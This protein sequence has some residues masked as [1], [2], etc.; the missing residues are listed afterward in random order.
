MVRHC[1]LALCLIAFVAPA[2]YGNLSQVEVEACSDG[3]TSNVAAVRFSHCSTLPCTVT[4]A[5][6]PRVEIDFQAPHDS[7]TLRVRV[8][9]AIGDMAPQP[10]PGFKTDACNFMGVS[11]PLKAGEKY[12]AKFDLTLSPTFPPVAAK[13]VFKGQDAAGEFFCFKV[14]VE[15]KH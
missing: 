3:S 5:D 9:G 15:L 4:L 1:A 10:F 11:C 7:K 12:T 14:P 6:K 13:A 2:V 8:L